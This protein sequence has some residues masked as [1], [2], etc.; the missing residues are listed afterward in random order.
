LNV[1]LYTVTAFDKFRSATHV[2]I[3]ILAVIE[4]TAVLMFGHI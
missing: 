1:G 2:Y 4:E 3:N